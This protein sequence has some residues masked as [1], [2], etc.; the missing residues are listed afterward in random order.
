MLIKILLFA[1]CRELIG[2]KHLELSVRDGLTVGQLKQQIVRDY[3]Q[4]RGITPSL[5]TAINM[6]Y[7]GDDA[8]LNSSDEVALIPPVSGG[9]DV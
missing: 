8:V 1:S 3:P 9:Q 6:E 7:V 5:S 2:A 4:M